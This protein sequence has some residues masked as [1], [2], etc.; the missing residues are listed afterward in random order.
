MVNL[1]A[2]CASMDKIN[3]SLCEQPAGALLSSLQIP[4]CLRALLP[5]NFCYDGGCL[6]LAGVKGENPPSLPDNVP[7]GRGS[8]GPP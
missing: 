3:L 2:D 5:P 7:S 6:G 8:N 1:S 4:P